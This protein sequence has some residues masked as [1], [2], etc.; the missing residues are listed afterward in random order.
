MTVRQSGTLKETGTLPD[1]KK[2][3]PRDELDPEIWND[4]LH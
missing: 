2:R 3:T 4:R 1:A